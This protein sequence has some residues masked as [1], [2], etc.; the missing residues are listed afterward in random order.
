MDKIFVIITSLHADAHFIILFNDR[1]AIPVSIKD[2]EHD[3]QAAK[4]PHIPNIFPK[5]DDIFP[6]A[7]EFNKVMVNSTNKIRLQKLVL[8]HLKTRVAQLPCGVLYYEGERVTNLNTDMATGDY[9]FKHLEADT[10]LLSIYSKLRTANYTNTAVIDSEDTDVYV[11]RDPQAREHLGRVGESLELKD[12]VKADMKAFIL[13]KVYGENI[14]LTCGQTRASK[15]P[16]YKRRVQSASHLM[17]THWTATAHEQ[18]TSHIASSIS[19][20]WNILP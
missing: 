6:T 13:S 11:Q 10:M 4:Y 9:G 19:L 5:P 8:K 16:N 17:M 14:A 18:I 2:D 1:Y 12:E 20:W 15:W 7:V 3:R